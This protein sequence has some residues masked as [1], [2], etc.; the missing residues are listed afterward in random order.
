MFSAYGDIVYIS[1]DINPFFRNSICNCFCCIY[2]VYVIDF[3]AVRFTDFVES[4][5]QFFCAIDGA[6]K[7]F[8]AQSLKRRIILIEIS[9]NHAK[10]YDFLLGKY[11]FSYS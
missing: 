6:G 1:L 2:F 7:E 9:G 4:E 11:G 10:S 5:A 3:I 8:L